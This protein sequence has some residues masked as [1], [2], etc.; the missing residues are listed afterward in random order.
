MTS[1]SSS[2]GKP[3][4][5]RPNRRRAAQHTMPKII[6]ASAR[7]DSMPDRHRYQ[8]NLSPAGFHD[9]EQRAHGRST[10]LGRNEIRHPVHIGLTGV[11]PVRV[12]YFRGVLR[13]GRPRLR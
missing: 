4:Q 12:P 11:Q 2:A 1:L 7:V 9:H 13:P 3:R 8:G 6:C 10:S 5:T